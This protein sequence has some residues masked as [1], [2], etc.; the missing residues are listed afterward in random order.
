M[1]DE[2]PIDSPPNPASRN[3]PPKPKSFW[4]V[5]WAFLFCFLWLYLV[6]L[7]SRQ[8]GGNLELPVAV[9]FWL[10][11]VIAA[12]ILYPACRPTHGPVFRG[13]TALLAGAALYWVALLIWVCILGPI[14]PV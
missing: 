4:R 3:S 10:P 14:V 13:L 1:P 9:Y 2:H 6:G 8:T 7:L 5:L 12:V 11:V